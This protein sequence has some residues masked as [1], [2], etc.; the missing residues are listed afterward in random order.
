MLFILMHNIADL[1]I[2][3]HRMLFSPG[4]CK[5]GYCFYAVIVYLSV[6]ASQTCRKG[7]VEESRTDSEADIPNYD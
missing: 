6:Y 4:I 7:K 1:T 5:A 3:N 2:R